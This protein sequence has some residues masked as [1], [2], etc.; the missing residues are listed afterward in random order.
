MKRRASLR[1]KNNNSD[2][3]QCKEEK[4]EG[5]FAELCEDLVEEL[6]LSDPLA[7]LPKLLFV[8]RVYYSAFTRN[9]NGKCWKAYYTSAIE[10]PRFGYSEYT[11]NE[12]GSWKACVSQLELG[13][14]KPRPFLL[15]E[16]RVTTCDEFLPESYIFSSCPHCRKPRI[17]HDIKEWSILR[18]EINSVRPSSNQDGVYFLDFLE[19][20]T[21]VGFYMGGGHYTYAW[22]RAL[23][24]EIHRL[25]QSTYYATGVRDIIVAALKETIPVDEEKK[26]ARFVGLF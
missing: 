19:P 26:M 15:V 4:K 14:L 13:I 24:N 22:Y 6:C 12:T 21:H 8:N 20:N 9:L 3:K 10:A 25:A 2:K 16:W 17:A 1:I 5:P 18:K 7:L 23:P 11:P